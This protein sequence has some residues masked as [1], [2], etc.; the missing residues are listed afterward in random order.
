MKNKKKMRNNIIFFYL[1]LIIF[2]VGGILFIFWPKK[3]KS[4]EEQR[5]LQQ[6]PIFSF[7]SL[8]SGK[9]STEIDKFYSDQFP[10]RS[11]FLEIDNKL[12]SLAGITQNKDDDIKFI[13][14]KKDDGGGAGNEIALDEN[15]NI[16]KKDSSKK[17]VESKKE[18]FDETKKESEEESIKETESEKEINI[19]Y[20]DEQT[21]IIIAQKRAMDIV[22]YSEELSVDYANLINKLYDKLP[23][24][25]KLY[26]M[27][28]PKPISY[29][30]PKELT[31][32]P[33]STVNAIKTVN[34]NLNTG[35]IPVD[36]YSI[37]NKHKE[38]YIF[39]RTDHHWNGR[40]AYY[41]YQ[42]FARKA[43][44]EVVNMDYKEPSYTFLGSMY[45]Y[46]NKNE[47]LREN[48]DRGEFF[49]PKNAGS[50]KNRFY[51][52]SS[53]SDGMLTFYLSYESEIDNH[54]MLYG[55]GDSAINHFTSDNKNGKSILVIKES[56]GNAFSPLLVD[57]YENVFSIDARYFEGDLIKFIVDN[58]INDVVVINNVSTLGN[59]TWLNGLDAMIK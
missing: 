22:Y 27:I 26:N 53:L 21:G 34:D 30:G 45:G 54:Y 14:A 37:L 5:A 7:E 13:T 38:E 57:N 23:N 20:N 1:F 6:M 16:V 40:G 24:N 10:F 39:F 44:I 50:A 25:V 9:F 48:P 4:V 31:E 33:Y 18:T 42:E 49:M 12:K 55:G 41:A 8:S 2:T 32:G 3:D 35:V 59:S 19:D 11:K 36:V 58:N 29:Y 46:T 17:V 51:S 15:G 28:I 52:D 47:I 43:G 56:F